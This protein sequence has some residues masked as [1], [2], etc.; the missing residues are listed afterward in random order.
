MP[1]LLHEYWSNDR[2]GEFGPVRA[3]TDRLRPTLVPNARFMFELRAE[4]WQQ[5]MRAYEALAYGETGKV[6][7]FQDHF[8]TEDER[9]TQDQ[10]LLIRS[11]DRSAEA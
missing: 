6:Y 1:D 3:E 2:G 7:D 8:Y 4:S 11:V 5:A 10:Y 9:E